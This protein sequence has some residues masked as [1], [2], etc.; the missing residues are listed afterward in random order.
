MAEHHLEPKRTIEIEKKY[1]LEVELT[2][3]EQM[4]QVYEELLAQG[5]VVRSKLG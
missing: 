3:E 2:S 1:I 4:I 5:I